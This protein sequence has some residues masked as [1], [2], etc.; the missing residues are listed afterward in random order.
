MANKYTAVAAH[1]WWQY[2]LLQPTRRR[3]QQVCRLWCQ[4]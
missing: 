4:L 1:C 2:A 3:T